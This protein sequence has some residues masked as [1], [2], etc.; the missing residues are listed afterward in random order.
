MPKSLTGAAERE[1]D[2]LLAVD[3]LRLLD[4][5]AVEQAQ[6]LLR[7]DLLGAGGGQQ[8]ESDTRRCTS[9]SRIQMN[10]PRKMRL[11][12]MMCGSYPR[13]PSTECDCQATVRFLGAFRVFAPGG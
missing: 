7:G 5:V 1:V 3:D 8:I 10:G 13:P 12:S 4:R 2:A 6:A 9:T 11:K